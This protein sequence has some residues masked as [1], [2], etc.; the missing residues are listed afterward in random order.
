M[1]IH[2]DVEKFIAIRPVLYRF[3]KE[4]RL[5]RKISPLG[6]SGYDVEI[7]LSKISDGEVENM[8]VRCANASNIKIGDIESMFGM[9][10]EIDDISGHQLE[11][12]S[13]RISEQENNTF[14]FDCSDFHVDLLS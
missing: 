8:K 13:Y 7:V 5:R 10:L 14:S 3:L 2:N 4:L 11:G 12:V 9:L 6:S 1:T